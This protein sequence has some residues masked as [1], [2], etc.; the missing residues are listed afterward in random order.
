LANK[1]IILE[2]GSAPTQFRF[3]MWADVPA[4]RQAFYADPTNTRTSA[5]KD[6]S[7]GELTALRTGTVVE[8]V[9]QFSQP[10]ANL[11]QI[12]TALEARFVAFQAEVNGANDWQRYGSRWDGTTWTD[13]GA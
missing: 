5:Y 9:E 13:A 10:G 11:A 1:I 6:A 12:K 7:A 4:A 8:R 2:R 3:A